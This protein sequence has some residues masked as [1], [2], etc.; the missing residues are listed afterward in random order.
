MRG[1]DRYIESMFTMSRLNDFVP[2]NHPLRP[3][4]L[5]LNDALSRIYAVF[6][7]MYEGDAKGGRPSIVPENL[8][9]ALLQVLY[10]ARS[11]AC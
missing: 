9:R 1:A 8:I 11:A 4:R 3:V 2:T 7:H 5:R 6:S 10:S